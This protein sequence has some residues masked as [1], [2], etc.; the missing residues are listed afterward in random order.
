MSRGVVGFF[1]LNLCPLLFGIGETIN[2]KPCSSKVRQLPHALY[3]WIEVVLWHR[4]WML[5]FSGS[6]F[7]HF[8]QGCHSAVQGMRFSGEW[9]VL[10]THQMFPETCTCSW[11]WIICCCGLLHCEYSE[12]IITWH[13]RRITNLEMVSRYWSPYLS[14]LWRTILQ[15]LQLFFLFIMPEQLLFVMCHNKTLAFNIPIWSVLICA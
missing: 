15:H 12:G 4:H 11:K 10:L 6:E 14:V 8:R 7:W 13:C 5:H 2:F 9:L 3:V 1:R